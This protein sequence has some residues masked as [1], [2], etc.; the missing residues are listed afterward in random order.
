[1][2]RTAFGADS[3]LISF[4]LHYELI[5]QPQFPLVN[6]YDLNGHKTF[7][8][9][10]GVGKDLLPDNDIVDFFLS[11]HL[12]TFFSQFILNREQIFFHRASK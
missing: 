9:F 5:K 2:L 1:L 7:Y 3:R 8:I 11:L 12:P 10:Y 4:F 6:Q